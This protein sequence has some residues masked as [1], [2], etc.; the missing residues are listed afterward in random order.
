MHIFAAVNCTHVPRKCTKPYQECE[1]TDKG[2]VC[3]CEYGY[4]MKYGV[5]VGKKISDKL[6]YGF[7]VTLINN[8]QYQTKT[9]DTDNIP[10][11]DQR[12]N[13]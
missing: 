4:T 8:F 2:P 3:V 6:H 10:Q 11:W 7:D 13:A 5:C 1:D 9:V 12:E